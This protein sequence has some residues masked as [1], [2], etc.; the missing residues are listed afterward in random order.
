MPFNN[1]NRCIVV[2]DLRLDPFSKY[3]GSILRLCTCVFFTALNIAIYFVSLHD[4][5]VV[6]SPWPT[7]RRAT[8]RRSVLRCVNSHQSVVGE[9]SGGE[10][11]ILMP[12]PG[13]IWHTVD[14]A[15]AALQGLAL[16]SAAEHH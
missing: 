13:Q 5:Y 11:N 14:Q 16:P 10:L 3:Y 8:R 12:F 6:G 7:T 2:V 1:S 15:A 9:L 4:R